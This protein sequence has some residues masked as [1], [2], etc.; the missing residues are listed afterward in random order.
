MGYEAGRASSPSHGARR[1]NA[2]KGA[3]RFPSL[4]RS[5][6]RA[7]AMLLTSAP[8]WDSNYGAV[9]EKEEKEKKPGKR[10][11]GTGQGRPSS[12]SIR[13]LLPGI[14]KHHRMASGS[15]PEW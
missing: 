12:S 5:L 1:E 15:S 3:V 6:R 13:A 14:G 4:A 9:G 10:L 8:R 7:N 11:A 2:G